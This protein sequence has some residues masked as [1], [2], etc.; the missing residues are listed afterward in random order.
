M[1]EVTHY[2]YSLQHSAHG[3]ARQ[4]HG[5]AAVSMGKVLLQINDTQYKLLLTAGYKIRWSP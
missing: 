4:N 5:Y 1:T 2:V 3:A